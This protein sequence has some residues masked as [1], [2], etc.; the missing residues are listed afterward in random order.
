MKVLTELSFQVATQMIAIILPVIF[1]HEDAGLC[2]GIDDFMGIETRRIQF[3]W[4]SAAE[5]AK[6][7]DVVNTT[8]AKIR[9]LGLILNIKK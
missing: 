7:A 2:S 9:E 3:S 8:V 4:V 5:G 6:W 1:T